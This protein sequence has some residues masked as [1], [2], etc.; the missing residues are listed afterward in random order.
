MVQTKEESL[1]FLE[2]AR[3]MVAE[4]SVAEDREKKMQQDEQQLKRTLETEIRQMTDAVQTTIKKR[5]QEIAASY[6]GEMDKVQEQ[7]KKARTKREKARNQGMKERIAE[8]TSELNSYNRELRD[9]MRETF[10]KDHVPVLCRNRWYFSLYFPRWGRELLRVLLAVL[11]VFLALPWGI[12]MLLPEQKTVWLVL[13]YLAD[14]VIFGGIYI[15]VGNRTRL[16]H[17]NALREGRQILD[18][19]YANNKKIKVITATI[20]KDKNEAF[21][22]LE[23]YDDEIARLEQESNEVS[24]RKREALGTF[25]TVTQNILQDEIESR[26][27]EKIQAMQTELDELRIQMKETA[28]EL[29][30]RR[31]TIA[32]DYAGHLGREFLDSFKLQELAGILRENRAATITEA[33]EVYRNDHTQ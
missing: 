21:Y 2:R 17:L 33:M 28:A 16:K 5:R 27:R 7:L 8:E 14:I 31:M 6:D 4:L 1:A 10:R 3:E 29:K 23:K 15:A 26:Y 18:Q 22:D 11:L 13:I 20:R 24:D 32:N 12:Y 25:E 19:I 9:R 30:E